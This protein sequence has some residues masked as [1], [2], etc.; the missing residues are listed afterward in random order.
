MSS[1]QTAT[2]TSNTRDDATVELP[3]VL[4]FMQLLWAVVHGVERR[5]KRM[6]SEIGITGPQRLVLRVAGLFPGLSAGDLATILHVHPSTLTGVL[7][8]L[9]EQ[10]LLVR[11]DDPRDRRKAVLKL[12]GRGRRVNAKRHGT[13]ESAVAE[14]LQAVSPR[15]RAATTRVLERLATHLGH[16]DVDSRR[17]PGGHRERRMK[18]STAGG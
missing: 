8:R 11:L 13:V 10:R 12:T 9:V 5:S 14:A 6:S 7:Q 15:D 3:D 17:T 2:P 16:A 18:G 1:K 4:Q